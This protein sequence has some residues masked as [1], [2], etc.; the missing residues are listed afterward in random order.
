MSHLSVEALSG[1]LQLIL[2]VIQNVDR[3]AILDLLRPLLELQLQQRVADDTNAD[4][5][6]ADIVLNARDRLLDVLQRRIVAE[7]LAG[8]IDLALSASK[9]LIDLSQLVL[10]LLNVLR[11]G[12]VLLLSR[13]EVLG[14]CTVVDGHALEATSEL[15]LLLADLFQILRNVFSQPL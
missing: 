4:V 5:D 14:V 3:L 1:G 7:S 12:L 8:V 6:S 10:E 13:F 9:L 11:H 15:I 2:I